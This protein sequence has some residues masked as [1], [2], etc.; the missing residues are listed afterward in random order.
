VDA[1]ARRNLLH[2]AVAGRAPRADDGGVGREAAGGRGAVLII[3][4]LRWD[5]LE[6][7]RRWRESRLD[8]AGAE[9]VHAP[10]RYGRWSDDGRRC[11]MTLVRRGA[12]GGGTAHVVPFR[13]APPDL[14]AEAQ[15]LWDAERR[16][17][18]QGIGAPWGT[19]GAICRAED[20]RRRW[21]DLF[22]AKAEMPDDRERTPLDARGLL[23]LDWPR[24]V[25]GGEPDFDVIL[26]A[27]TVP[28]EVPPEASE[29]AAALL[30]DEG[31]REYFYRNRLSGIT[32]F[33]DD[34]IIREM[35]DR[36]R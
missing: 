23:D 18:G 22:A 16:A 26:A 35:R 5:D 29:I 20:W 32:T 14:E 36:I 21:A 7:R 9:R 1:G 15:A 27:V 3:G 28:E 11:T 4:S 34:A 19:V 6:I 2:F 12:G 17:E 25:G 13:G 33:Q 8:A 31:A 10:I 30:A 24:R